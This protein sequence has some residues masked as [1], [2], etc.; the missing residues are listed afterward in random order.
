MHP[1]QGDQLSI[2]VYLPRAKGAVERESGYTV[3]QLWMQGML[4]WGLRDHIGDGIVGTTTGATV[5]TCHPLHGFRGA[6]T[7]GEEEILS[8]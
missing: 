4:V 6:G 2:D 1:D 3:C 7:C 8:D 5:S